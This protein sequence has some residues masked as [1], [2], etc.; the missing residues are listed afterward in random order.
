MIRWVA[1]ALAS[2]ADDL[3]VSVA[4]EETGER[5]LTVLPGIRTIPDERRERGPIEGLHRGMEAARG[6]IVLVAPCDAPRIRPELYDLLL[7]RLRSHDVAA[8]QLEAVDPV[9]AVYRKGPAL[10]ALTRD[11]VPSPS[12]LVD[13]LDAVYVGVSSLRKVDPALESFLDVNT[14]ADLE[15]VEAASR[16][17]PSDEGT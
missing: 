4:S 3:L 11:E 8:P 17:E 9:R 12:A 14:D 1:E 2:R 16:E 13:R 7:E 6:D 10:R 15:R 5:L